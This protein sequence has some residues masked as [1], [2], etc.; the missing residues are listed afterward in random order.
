[1]P[2]CR[3]CLLRLPLLLLLLLRLLLLLFMLS[4][5]ASSLVLATRANVALGL[6]DH[7]FA[8]G[9]SVLVRQGGGG[10]GRA[11]EAGGGAGGDSV[12]VRQWGGR[13]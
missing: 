3:V 6:P 5:Q 4:P 10:R 13:G 7:L 9:D 12:L 1:M 2:C 11:G 8:L